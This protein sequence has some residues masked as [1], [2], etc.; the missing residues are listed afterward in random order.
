MNST[1]M[2]ISVTVSKIF[3]TRIFSNLLF[4][5]LALIC[6]V[7]EDVHDVFLTHFAFQPSIGREDHLI[8]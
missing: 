1:L 7:T 4:S 3:A 2:N 6:V 8:C 5:M